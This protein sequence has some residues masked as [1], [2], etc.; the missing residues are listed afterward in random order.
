MKILFVAHEGRDGIGT[1]S[2]GLRRAIPA[3]LGPADEFVVRSLTGTQGRRVARIVEQQLVLPFADRDADLVHLP[4]FRSSPLDR[5]RVLLTVHDVCFLDRPE[6]FPRS[7]RAYKSALLRLAVTMRPAAIVCVSQYTK[8]RLIHHLPQ[9]S[10]CLH[11]ISP[12]ID[13]PS[14]APSEPTGDESYFLTISTIEPRKNHLG[15]L[16]A[17]QRARTAGLRLR[18]LVAGTVGYNGGPI[19][20]ALNAA[21]GV[22][23]IGKVSDEERERLFP[24]A[25]FVQPL[26][27][28]GVRDPA[29]RPWSEAC[30]SWRRQR[31]RRGRPRRSLRLDPADVDG[32]GGGPGTC[33]THWRFT[34]PAPVAS[35]PPTACGGTL[36]PL[37]TSRCTGR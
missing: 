28:R 18:W 20:A 13:L 1:H 2:A 15:L 9:A 37:S 31:T 19:A 34:R 25:A 32:L 10:N 14:E 17:F 6:W 4:D 16:A 8:Q 30:P 29:A 23:V 7:V 12:G 27:R 22:D 11:V 33:R 21:D 35:R 3:A 24:Y 5:H 36:P 26:V